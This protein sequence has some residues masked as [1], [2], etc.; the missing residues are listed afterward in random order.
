M[1]HVQQVPTSVA[2]HAPILPSKTTFRSALDS[3]GPASLSLLFSAACNATIIYTASDSFCD[4][5]KEQQK[6]LG[7]CNS[8]MGS[9]TLLPPDSSIYG[10]R[11]V[12]VYIDDYSCSI[13]GSILVPSATLALT[14]LYS[15]RLSDVPLLGALCGPVHPKVPSK[16]I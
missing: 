15:K 4:S 9:T 13:S 10:A 5:G 7:S 12:G 14:P 16:V 2:A 6:Q 8:S 1:R 11:G 3:A